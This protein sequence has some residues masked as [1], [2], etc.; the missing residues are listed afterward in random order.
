MC[1]FVVSGATGWLGKFTVNY[2]MKKSGVHAKDIFCIGSK[3]RF[4]IIGGVEHQIYTFDTLPKIPP[5]KLYFD[6]G[7]LTR[8]FEKKLEP[9]EYTKA[10]RKIISES[11]VYI[12]SYLP[13][14]V[15]LASSGAVYDTIN[16]S[17]SRSIYGD[18][19]LEQEIR[20]RKVTEDINSKLSI[21]R[22][23]NISGEFISK[24]Q[25][26]ALHDFII[27]AAV[28]KVI[29]ITSSSLVLRRYCYIGEIIQLIMSMSDNG[30]SC[31]FDSGGYEIELRQLAQLISHIS[32]ANVTII[33]KNLDRS[34]KPNIYCSSNDLYEKLLLKFI[35]VLPMPI[36]KQIKLTYDSIFR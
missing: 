16:N 15:F 36:D 8:D 23:F 17:G 11:E 20:I 27:S 1:I 25:V 3:R 12:K 28:D 9:E 31:D 18:L 35:G 30:Y 6:Y 4:E 22:I 7:F 34:L 21:C 29:E 14:Y 19:K 32:S 13:E 24:R 5:T 2:L 33:D 26:F 10:N